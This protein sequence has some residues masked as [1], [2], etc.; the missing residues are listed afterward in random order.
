M[1]RRRTFLIKLTLTAM[2]IALGMVLP[3]LTGQIPQIGKMLLPMHV[4]VFLCALI[5]G[6]KFGTPAAFILPLFRS[7]IF[8]MPVF[9]PSAI[10][11][12]FELAAYAFVAGFLFEKLRLKILPKLFISLFASM[13]AGR[14]VMGA[15]NAILLG[16]GGKSYSFAAFISGAFITAYP[17]IIVQLILIPAVMLALYKAKLIPIGQT[18]RSKAPDASRP[19]DEDTEEIIELDD[20]T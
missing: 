17:G 2:F 13:L 19:E 11:M 16:F 9:Y 6:W 10:S 15:A 7:L 14:A 18:S 8:G 4:P 12:A 1:Y 20:R 3:F 5:C